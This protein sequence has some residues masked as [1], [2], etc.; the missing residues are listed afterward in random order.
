MYFGAFFYI[1][2]E[3][4]ILDQ[5]HVWFLANRMVNLYAAIYSPANHFV[6]FFLCFVVFILSCFGLSASTWWRK[7]PHG[8]DNERRKKTPNTNNKVSTSTSS[9]KKQLGKKL[10]SQRQTQNIMLMRILIQWHFR[11]YVQKKPSH[12]LT[13]EHFTVVSCVNCFGFIASFCYMKQYQFGMAG[14]E[15][16]SH[17]QEPKEDSQR[18]K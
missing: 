3:M 9:S 1:N 12:L 2:C 7:Q 5:L 4:R 15:N 6:F 13:F 14:K 17:E 8:K 11:R 16:N 18:Q 10:M